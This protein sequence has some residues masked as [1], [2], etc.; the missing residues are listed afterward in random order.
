MRVTARC[1]CGIK[2]IMK[3]PVYEK[4]VYV[5]EGAII[6]GNVTLHDNANVWYNAVIRA[7]REPVVIGRGSNIQDNCVIH[8]ESGSGV[9]IGENVTIGHNAVVHGCTIGD[10][11]LVGMGAVVMNN[12]VIGK[13]CIIGACALVTQGTIIPDNSLVMGIPAS[14]VRMLKPE[15]IQS[16]IENARKY[17]KEAAEYKN[18]SL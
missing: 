18:E 16:N 14:F 12:A 4:N 6:R 11:T 15:E 17:V 13:N 1:N 9:T 5:A 2:N 3:K 10:N 7:D 8:V